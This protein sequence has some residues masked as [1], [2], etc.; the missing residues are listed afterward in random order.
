MC[1]SA[2]VICHKKAGDDACKHLK[3]ISK[4]GSCLEAV[5]ATPPPFV[6]CTDD[7]VV[8]FMF[9]SSMLFFYFNQL[10]N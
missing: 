4:T 2:A 9:A 5:G 7:F 6:V 1:L 8:G 3:C 10:S